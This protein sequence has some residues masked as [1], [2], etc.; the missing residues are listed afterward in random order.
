MGLIT[1][2]IAVQII[3]S[4]AKNYGFLYGKLKEEIYIK[5]P[6]EC[7]VPTNFVYDINNLLIHGLGDL[8]K[9]R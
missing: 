8:L 3:L 2:V 6:L 5:V 4:P 9:P 7:E 1:K